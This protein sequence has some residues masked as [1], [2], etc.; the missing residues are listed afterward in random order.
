M[1]QRRREGLR[2]RFPDAGEYEGGQLV[3]EMTGIV[4]T[5]KHVDA[6]DDYEAELQGRR[7]RGGGKAEPHRGTA[8]TVVLVV[9]PLDSARALA[10]KLETLSLRT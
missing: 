4:R 9:L 1:R 8:T 6:P 3:D 2:K 10:T 5:R 7:A